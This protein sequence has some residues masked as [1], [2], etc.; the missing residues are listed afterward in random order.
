LPTL[1]PFG[2][3]S[4]L[5]YEGLLG[6]D[7]SST[8]TVTGT[9]ISFTSGTGVIAD[10]GNGFA[11]FAVGDLVYIS[12]AAQTGNNGWHGLVTAKAAGSLTVQSSLTTEAAGASVTV[13]TT[14]CKDG[15]LLKS[16]SGEWDMTDLS[17]GFRY[18]KGLRVGEMTLRWQVDNYVEQDISFMGQAPSMG[19]ATIGTGAGTAA[20]SNPF[21][22]ALGNYARLHIGGVLSTLNISSF[23]L[24]ANNNIEARKYIGNT[25][26]PSGI[27]V[28]ALDVGVDLSFYFDTAGR[29]LQ[30]MTEAHTETGLWWAATS[31]AGDYAFSLPALKPDEG[32]PEISGPDAANMGNCKLTAHEST[33]YGY[34]MAMFRRAA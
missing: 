7:W 12:G 6:N 29:A 16:Y 10:S 5:L 23:S 9:T 15:I 17:Q 32:D 4:H 18:S 28:R 11:S 25:A 26:G 27:S 13:Q 21:M 34:Q 19:T 8:I 2:N 3:F 30:V 14:R 22:N 33:T 1:L 31:S 20:S 24:S